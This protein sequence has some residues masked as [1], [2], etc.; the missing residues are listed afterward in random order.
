MTI[1]FRTKSKKN[2]LPDGKIYKDHLAIFIFELFKTFFIHAYATYFIQLSVSN[3]S[4][5]NIVI[6][7]YNIRLKPFFD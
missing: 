7:T 2:W 3:R 6:K 5:T 1:I 4:V